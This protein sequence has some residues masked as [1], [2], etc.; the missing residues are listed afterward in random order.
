MKRTTFFGLVV[1]ALALLLTPLALEAAGGSSTPT[2]MPAPA[3]SPQEEARAAY[4]RGL[5]LRDKAWKLEE[6]AVASTESKAR[7]KLETKVHKTFE[8]ASREFR[9]AT[10]A[11][12][13]MFQA[14]SSLGYSLRRTGD[15]EGSLDAYNRAL[16]IEP[17]YAEAVEYRAEAYL[18]LD[19]LE[20][21]KTAYFQL[22]RFDRER[23]DELMTAMERWVER[24]SSEPGGL[25]R[26]TIAAFAAWV[27]E[28]AQISEQ[29]ARLTGGGTSSW[30]NSGGERP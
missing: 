4:E 30:S 26:A 18:G 16:E 15:Y 29:T 17:R 10:R 23:S 11:N 28:R 6:K 9:A 27:E 20:E 3:R 24:R 14:F 22:F 7:Q 25:D 1:V 8:K 12:P 19:R 2:P 5:R 21:A 13:R